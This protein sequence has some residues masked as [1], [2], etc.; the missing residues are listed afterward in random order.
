MY[1]IDLQGL[2][3]E[4]TTTG[5]RERE[6]LEYLVALAFAYALAFTQA[7]FRGAEPWSVAGWLMWIA[8][9]L[10]TIGGLLVCFRR[11]GGNSGQQFLERYLSV[12]WVLGMRLSF[13]YLVVWF[14]IGSLVHFGVARPLVGRLIGVAGLSVNILFWYRMQHHIHEI[15]SGEP[16][17]T[18]EPTRAPEGARGSP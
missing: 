13:L 16:N 17:H 4:L 12:G 3:R 18:V 1:F 11:N 8:G 15:A 9:L 6:K 7:G 14:S 2:K 5:L 10:I